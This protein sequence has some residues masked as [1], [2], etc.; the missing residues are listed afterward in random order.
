MKKLIYL[1]LFLIPIIINGQ[2]F[3]AD[4]STA[5]GQTM[6][7]DGACTANQ[8]VSNAAGS[9][10]YAGCATGGAEDGW[11]YFVATSTS[12][13]VTYTS[14]NNRDIAIVVYQGASCASLS[15]LSCTDRIFEANGTIE[16]AEITTVSGSPY[17]IRIVDLSSNTPNGSVCVRNTPVN[18]S[19]ATATTLVSGTACSTTNGTTLNATES[20]P[21][22][23][24]CGGNNN[25]DVWYSFVATNTNQ[26]ILVNPVNGM[27]AVIQIFTGSCAALS[28]ALCEDSWVAGYPESVVAT[29]FT[30]GTT[31]YFR[32]YDFTSGTGGAFSVCVNAP[33]TPGANNNCPGAIS[34]SDGVSVNGSN[35][36]FD[37][38]CTQTLC[39][40][41]TTIDCYV[42][43]GC[44]LTDYASC[45][46]LE[47][48]AWYT[49]TPATSGN[50]FFNM[51][52]QQ[53]GVGDGMQMW[54]G[55]ATGACPTANNFSQ[56]LCQST[57]TPET[58]TLNTNLTAGTQYY[59]VVD[60]FAGDQCN[61]SL[62]V[63]STISLPINL[64]SLD[65]IR[66]SEK[67]SS[68]NWK[69]IEFKNLERFDIER[70]LDAV[71]FTNIGSHQIEKNESTEIS[72]F[73]FKDQ[74]CPD[75]SPY[76]YRLK[77]IDENGKVDYSKIVQLSNG[78][79]SFDNID[80]IRLIPN[81]SNDL[82]RL[83]FSTPKEEKL[84]LKILSINSTLILQKTFDS[85][86]GENNIE[87][88]TKELNSG[89]Y[90]VILQSKSGTK[91]CKLIKQ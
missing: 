13:A 71:N 15:V 49:F 4:C 46:S 29:G 2:T 17:Y 89:I 70:S 44:V 9:P 26:N 56:I 72:S 31:Y 83:Y 67:T 81:P 35:F 45:M 73:S 21:L 10:A 50:F 14:T 53:C 57:A 65:A 75:I 79:K 63:S 11:L 51:Y 19:C 55:T 8:N 90:F 39:A 66:E 18:N 33:V 80:N 68:I 27:D 76:Y 16:A 87:I 84:E 40:D 41:P 3:S 32:I 91:T 64:L 62:L 77:Y 69:T 78:I 85:N 58:I 37:D 43:A 36:G 5:A 38:Q 86:V 1:I 48:N 23:T 54:L 88:S 60:G 12:T 59:L 28:S 47:T 30:V 42:A 7:V 82:T 6:T 25:D 22:A 61:Y 74:N 34:I 20:S 52:N 24:A